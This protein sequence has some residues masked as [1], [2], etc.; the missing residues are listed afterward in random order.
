MG[1]VLMISSGPTK[2][3]LRRWA[4]LKRERSWSAREMAVPKKRREGPSEV[5]S[6]ARGRGWTGESQGLKGTESEKRNKQRDSVC[7]WVPRAAGPSTQP[8]VGRD[9]RQE[10]LAADHQRRQTWCSEARL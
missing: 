9:V 10:L 7:V 3:V 5:F 1:L 4:S 8:P 6:I 2:G